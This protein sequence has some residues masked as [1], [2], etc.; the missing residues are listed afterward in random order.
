MGENDFQIGKL[1]SSVESLTKSV[2][3]LQ[4]EIKELNSFK[5]RIMTI[6]TVLSGVIGII[7]AV[8]GK[9]L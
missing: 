2:D 5:V 8:L 1:V 4:A 6:S 9:I 7:V 3:T